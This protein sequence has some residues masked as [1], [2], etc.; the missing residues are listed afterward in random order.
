MKIC[1]PIKES[2]LSRNV[3]VHYGAYQP[4]FD[5]LDKMRNGDWLPLK[6]ESQE[7]FYRVENRLRTHRPR[8]ILQVHRLI[9]ELTIY[10][11]KRPG[12]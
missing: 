4:I 1:K 8:G 2:G 6:C 11:R 9:K 7:E 10:V 5:A 12:A 3:P